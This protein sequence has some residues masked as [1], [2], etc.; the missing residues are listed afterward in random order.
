MQEQETKGP[1]DSGIVPHP[2][3]GALKPIGDLESLCLAVEF[4]CG[5]CCKK[6][7]NAKIRKIIDKFL[8][9]VGCNDGCIVVKTISGG[10]LVETQVVRAIAI[11]IDR[12]CSVS[13]DSVQL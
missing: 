13:V 4:E 10:Q 2:L 1:I 7:L 6:A 8:V 9:L 3:L 5:E 11:P 12:I